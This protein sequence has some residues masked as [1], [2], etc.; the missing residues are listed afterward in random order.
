MA[1]KLTHSGNVIMAGFFMMLLFMSFLVYKCM[2]QRTDMVSANYYEKELH[3]QDNIDAKRNGDAY[4]FEVKVNHSGL[5]VK[6]PVELAAKMQDATISFYCAA[7]SRNDK[8]LKLVEG[9]GIYTIST[10]GW[11][12][13]SYIAKISLVNNG[14][15]YYKEIPVT[16]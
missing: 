4:L 8:V 7:D 12:H 6:I 16:I 10:K 13:M 15:T 11:K 2:T 5:D 3:F 9:N 1:N 14:K